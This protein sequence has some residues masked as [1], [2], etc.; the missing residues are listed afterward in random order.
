MIVLGLGGGNAAAQMDNLGE[1]FKRELGKGA[2]GAGRRRHHIRGR[3]EA[4]ETSAVPAAMHL[5]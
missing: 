4:G 5:A 3:A 2:A 1:G